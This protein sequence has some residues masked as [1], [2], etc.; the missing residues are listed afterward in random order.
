MK[1]K[2]EETPQGLLRAFTLIELL[3]VVGII[4]I[5]AGGLGLFLRGNNPASALRSAQGLAMGAISAA[6]G[7]AALSQN[8]ACLVVQADNNNE[9]FLRSIR[10]VVKDSTVTG[11]WR[12]VGDE[13]ILPPGVFFV[14]PATLTGVTLKD[15]PG[16]WPASRRSSVFASGASNNIVA[17][18]STLSESSSLLM[19][20]P[21]SSLGKIDGGSIVIAPGRK[22]SAS[23]VEIENSS[24]ARGLV[25]SQYGVAALVNEGA[26]FGN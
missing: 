6:R 25:L 7:Q 4:G 10:V 3:V 22:T 13:I 21:I 18:L 15:D 19:S 14:P 2:F 23:S 5:L 16:T 17:N 20:K 12:Q 8:D 26:S 1:L 24:A 9:N 11:S